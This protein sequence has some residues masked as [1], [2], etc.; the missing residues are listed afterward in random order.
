MDAMHYEAL[1]ALSRCRFLPGSWDKRFVRNLS[2]L[3]TEADLTEKQIAQIE[4]LVVRFRNQLARHGYVAPIELAGAYYDR[5]RLAP[6]P[7]AV[8]Y[9]WVG[10]PS[11]ETPPVADDDPQLSLW[12]DEL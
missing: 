7:N 4:R 3:P 11:P 6:V 10:E 12:D 8:K 5:V 2:G 9:A 1:Q